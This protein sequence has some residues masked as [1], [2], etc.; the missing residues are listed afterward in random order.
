MLLPNKRH[1][2][3]K[4][5]YD[6]GLTQSGRQGKTAKPASNHTENNK[7]DPNTERD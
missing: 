2:I 4:K 6:P 3:T 1:N 7:L 5:R